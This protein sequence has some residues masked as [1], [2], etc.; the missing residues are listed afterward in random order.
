MNKKVHSRRKKHVNSSVNSREEVDQRILAAADHLP[1]QKLESAQEFEEL[2]KDEDDGE[3]QSPESA[4]GGVS[5]RVIA[6]PAIFTPTNDS[7]DTYL[8]KFPDLPNTF[9]EGHGLEDAY[10]MASDVLAEMNYARKDLPSPSLPNNIEKADSEFVVIVSA[11]LTAKER[12][13]SQFRS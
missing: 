5:D 2:F 9:T 12:E 6:Y 10:V 1:T 8:I 13:I 4:A 11:N 7:D 3:T